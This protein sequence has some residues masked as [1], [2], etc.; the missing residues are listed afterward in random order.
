MSMSLIASFL[1]GKTCLTEVVFSL[2]LRYVSTGMGTRFSLHSSNATLPHVSGRQNLRSM[3]RY[4]FKSDLLQ[5]SQNGQELGLAALH[6]FCTIST[7]NPR[8]SSLSPPAQ[9]SGNR[10]YAFI[11][12]QEAHTYCIW[13]KH[14]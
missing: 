12:E 11:N 4:K 10:L 6:K 8:A 2:A 13:N 9:Q 1:E 14:I 3:S 5:E 7:N